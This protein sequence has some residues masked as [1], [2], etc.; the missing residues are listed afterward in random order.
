MQHANLYKRYSILIAYIGALFISG[1]S[2]PKTAVESPQPKQASASLSDEELAQ[3]KASS[4]QWQAAKAGVE[5]LLVI[6]QDLKLLISQLNAVANQDTASTNTPV[7]PTVKA[8]AETLSPKV[9]Q[10][11]Q[12]AT[13]AEK[14]AVK[15]LFALQVAAVTD[16]DRLSQSL[17]EIKASAS[18][19]FQGEF[20][21]NVET[22]NVSGVTYYR[23]KLGAYQEQANAAADCDK[24]KQ[25]Q[26]NCIVSHY[27]QQPLK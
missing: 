13:N 18:S 26:I 16:K 5:R 24:L 23:L 8:S 7:V 17:N 20:V 2:S 1:C 27:T 15:A 4:Q 3:L 9:A 25:R 10:K 12:V 21:A 11:A 6:E 14:Q 19:L 22:I